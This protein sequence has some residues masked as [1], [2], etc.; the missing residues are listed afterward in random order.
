MTARVCFHSEGNTIWNTEEQSF[1]FHII[2]GRR[3]AVVVNGLTM[4]TKFQPS[5]TEAHFL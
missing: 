4:A 3:G 5:L 2:Y 1:R